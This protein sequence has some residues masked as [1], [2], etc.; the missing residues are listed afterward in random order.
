MELLFVNWDC[1]SVKKDGRQ[2]NKNIDEGIDK[3]G[4]E[5]PLQRTVCVIEKVPTDLIRLQGCP[6]ALSTIF[7]HF[8]TAQW[9]QR[10]LLLL[11]IVISYVQNN[12]A[13]KKKKIIIVSTNHSVNFFTT[14]CMRKILIL[15]IH[16]ML[17]WNVTQWRWQSHQSKALIVK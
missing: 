6:K 4:L 9:R 15:K 3:V 10:S 14:F 13:V 16:W 12:D 17:T 1:K 8:V 11:E 5:Q 7:S 2:I